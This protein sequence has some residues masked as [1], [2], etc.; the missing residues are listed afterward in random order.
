MVGTKK[1]GTPIDVTKVTI[2]NNELKP[3]GGNEYPGETPN[4]DPKKNND[5]PTK[6]EPSDN[7]TTIPKEETTIKTTLNKELPKTGIANGFF[8]AEVV[9]ILAGVGILILSVKKK[10]VEK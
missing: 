10:K 1:D 8:T 2:T 9:A 5:I 6:E 4:N 3:G 7:Q